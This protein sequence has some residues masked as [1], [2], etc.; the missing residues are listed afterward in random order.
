MSFFG[1]KSPLVA[2]VSPGVK[3]A[4]KYN[5]FRQRRREAQSKKV[6][7]RELTAL[8]HKIVSFNPKLS[9]F[10]ILILIWA[11]VTKKSKK[12]F[13]LNPFSVHRR[14]VDVKPWDFCWNVAQI[15]SFD[16]HEGYFSR[17]VSNKSSC[18]TKKNERE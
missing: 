18:E 5:Q 3:L 16:F 15:A 9:L 6:T 2:L 12:N 8:N 7:E 17:E 10:L 1:R 11:K 14:L 13:C 4:R